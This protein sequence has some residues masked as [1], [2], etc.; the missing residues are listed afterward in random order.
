MHEQAII[1]SVIDSIRRD[2]AE[3]K[4]S[5]RVK[6]ISLR[7]GALELHGEES[8]KQIFAVSAAGT[9]LAGA[10]LELAVIPA[11]FKCRCGFAGPADEGVDHHSDLPI[12]ECPR[13]GTVCRVEGGRGVEGIELEVEEIPVRRPRRGPRKS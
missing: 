3:R 11:R 13:C 2:L 6:S 7:I 1:Q 5:G 8:F 12:A 4:L 9:Q 10:E